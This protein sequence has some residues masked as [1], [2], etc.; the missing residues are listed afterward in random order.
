MNTYHHWKKLGQPVDYLM[1]CWLASQ[2]DS[3]ELR[4]A[5]DWA[6]MVPSDEARD[7]PEKAW[8]CLMFAVSDSRF[9]EKHLGYLAASTLEDLLS[10]HGD[11]FIERVEHEAL[12]NLRFAVM[13]AG[14]WQFKMSHH[15]WQ[16]VKKVGDFKGSQKNSIYDD[17]DY[18][19]D[20]LAKGD[21]DEL[22]R[23]KA[24]LDTFPKGVDQFV[25]RHW[26]TNAIDCGSIETIKWIL[27]HS[28]DLTFVDAEGFT[29][30]LSAIDRELP[31]KYEIMEL[32][33]SY[34]APVNKQG[35]NDY[36]PL[37]LAAVREDIQ[38]L[39][40]LIAHKANTSIKTQ[41]DSYATP[42]EQA[43]LCGCKKSVQYLKSL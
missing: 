26:I 34:G 4:E 9:S 5:N 35:F 25:Q 23:V 6:L 43:K 38:A 37:H 2:S 28:V 15:I 7:S 1:E 32:L 42:L 31:H 13:L 21:I 11:D 22:E 30:L 14:V 8:E 39:E 36:T 20:L 41:I 16:R 33:I 17:Y 19:I 10:Y 12:N 27:S 40:I 29:P 24:C 3:P 18:L